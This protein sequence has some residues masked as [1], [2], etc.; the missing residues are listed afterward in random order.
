M[1]RGGSASDA[2]LAQVASGAC[3]VDVPTVNLA[4]QTLRGNGRKANLRGTRHV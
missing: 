2:R 4:A 1:I 3:T